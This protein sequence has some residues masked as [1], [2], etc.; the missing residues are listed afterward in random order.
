MIPSHIFKGYDIRGLYPEE[1]NEENIKTIVSA[2]Y[3][4]F[5]K[6]KPKNDKLT[7][8][9]GT[10]MRVSSPSLTKA[11]IDTLVS[12]GANIVDIGV[13]STP[14]FYFAVS[15]Y[16]YECGMQITASHNPP[17]WNGV[18]FVKKGN[19][20]LV[21]IGKPTGMDD[22]KKMV[23]ENDLPKPAPGGSI[24]KKSGILKDEVENSLKIIGS[25]NIGTFKIVAD[26]ANAMGSQYI[27]A[28]FKR[29]PQELIRM[30][31]E[32]DGTFPAHQPDPLQTE[33]L[34]D[35]QKRVISENADLGLA[36]DGDGDRLFFIDE[37]G[38]IVPPAIITSI[39]ASELLANHPRDTIYVDIRY[40]FTPKKIIEEAGGKV[41]ITRV[42]HAYITEAMN[43]TGGIFAGE[44]S[45]HYFFRETGNAESQMP[46]ILMIL[47]VLTREG[48]PFSE[49]IEQYR[50]SYESGEFNFKI[51]NAAEILD[52]LSQK[53]KDGELKT[54]DGVAISYP[55]WRFS[56]RT[57]NT[58]P[59]LRLNVEAYELNVMEAKRDEIKALIESLAK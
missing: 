36:P 32:L 17:Q 41:E 18:K 10:D 55:D 12:L 45:A 40:L 6:G 30:N 23:L 14:T 46:V 51:T 25:P 9:V 29:V 48:K 1:L 7:L 27:E 4:F 57:S 38:N 33:T 13:V 3:K 44:S 11:A 47:K 39:V 15:H 49:I 2:I 59:L 24:V 20:G 54:M 16:G 31:W 34:V 43:K 42:G 52:A 58:E 8:V 19:R 28:L 53:Y 21:K 50:K 56:V 35:L 37:K 22:V 26:P 5:K